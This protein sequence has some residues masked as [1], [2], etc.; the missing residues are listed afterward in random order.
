MSVTTGAFQGG[1]LDGRY[2]ALPY[3]TPTF[4]VER[5]DKPII[6]VD[7]AKPIGPIRPIR[8][9]Y[10]LVALEHDPMFRLGIVRSRLYMWMGWDSDAN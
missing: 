4:E 2:I 5:V 9:R 8:G 10:R 6:V 3:A 7:R 1:P